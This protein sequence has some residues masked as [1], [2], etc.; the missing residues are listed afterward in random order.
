MKRMAK[1]AGGKWDPEKRLWLIQYGKI[2]GTLLEKHI[3]V[4]AK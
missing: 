2:K 3:I 1:A 4:D